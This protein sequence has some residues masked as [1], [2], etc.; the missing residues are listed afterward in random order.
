M[1]ERMASGSEFISVQKTFR[2]SV[3]NEAEHAGMVAQAMDAKI[4]AQVMDILDK[5]PSFYIILLQYAK[6]CGLL[7]LLLVLPLALFQHAVIKDA[8]FQVSPNILRSPFGYLFRNFGIRGNCV[9]AHTTICGIRVG[10]REIMFSEP[11]YFISATGLI[12]GKVTFRID[13]NEIVWDKLFRP[14]NVRRKASD[15]AA[16]A[17]EAAKS[18]E[19]AGQHG[20]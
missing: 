8:G 6:I 4:V 7:W 11:S 5:T 19:K 18:M 20:S 17:M 15:A 9:Y 13:G 10:S 14:E 1:V 2:I 16:K 12:F 3:Q